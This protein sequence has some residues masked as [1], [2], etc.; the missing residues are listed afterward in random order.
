MRTEI[1]CGTSIVTGLVVYAPQWT[2]TTT[3]R[4]DSPVRFDWRHVP[5]WGSRNL[6][7]A[8]QSVTFTN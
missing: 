6:T 8:F 3:P 4:T 1:K 5:C 2:D 7:R